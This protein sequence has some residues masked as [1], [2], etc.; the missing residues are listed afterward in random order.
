VG[1]RPLGS[2]SL[3]LLAN[4]PLIPVNSPTVQA[5]LLS[6][7]QVLRLLQV[8]VDFV[9]LAMALLLALA[10]R[11]EGDIPQ[12]M[13]ER[14]MLNAPLVLTVQ[15]AALATSGAHRMIW[16]YF[17][18]RD[19]ARLARSILVAA[20]L[21]LLFR[22]IAGRVPAMRPLLVPFG[23]LG[24]DA[25][26]AFVGLAGT[27]ALRRL[28]VEA[29]E[30]KLRQP[31]HGR[32]TKVLL[33]G[34]GRGGVFLS[35]EL[36]SRPDQGYLPIGFVDDD[37]HKVGQVVDGLPV[38]GPT[39][40]LEKIC[41]KNS[42]ERLIIT[43]ASTS[44][45]ELRALSDRASQVGLPVM[46]VPRLFDLLEGAPGALRIRDVTIEDLLGRPPVTL[47]VAGLERFIEGKTLLVS[48]AGGS[49]GSEIC[50]QIVRFRPRR[51]VLVERFE[52]ALFEIHREL[53]E[54]PGSDNI[55]FVPR[56]CDITDSARVEQVMSLDRPNLIIHAAAHKHVPMMELN[57]GEA[58]K[59]NV[60]GTRVLADSAVRHGVERFV[61]ISTDKAVNP[62]SVMGATKRVAEL[63]VHFKNSSQGTQF[64]TVRFGNVLGSAG[65]V[66]PIF[67]KQI[68]KGGPVTVTHPDMVRFFMTIPEACQLVLQAGAL[69][70]GGEVY[71]LDMGAPVRIVDLARDLIRLSGF[72][73]E[74]DIAIE[75]SG[76]RPG[77]KLF[78]ELALADKENLRSLHPGIFVVETQGLDGSSLTVLVDELLRVAYAGDSREVLVRLRS[79][80]PEFRSSSADPS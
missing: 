69:S 26:L 21:L 45:S 23:V 61:M 5:S 37:P 35:R 3:V 32:S 71:V 49:I 64:A 12:E 22:V 75:F 19:A 62:T 70:Q 40:E 39:R 60:G 7:R 66:V 53:I 24:F 76:I 57:P 36:R 31:R 17:S 30:Q 77:E 68:A 38:L 14:V 63:Y 2:Q 9:T 34:A 25:V 55:E 18:L 44:A 13:F 58:V 72:R 8:A 79:V 6:T 29:S 51:L 78:E 16:R 20:A 1:K 33:I 15:F 56:I 4:S 47:D 10:I 42:I 59:N 80:V 54:Q 67:K 65:S 46:F 11:F 52:N 50:R 41:E 43:V 27:R 74:Q 73:P 28:D 48:G